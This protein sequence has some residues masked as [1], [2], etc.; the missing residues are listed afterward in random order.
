[1]ATSR[2]SSAGY[3][4][5][6]TPPRTVWTVVRGDTAS[7]KVYVTDDAK[8]PLNIPD[9]TISMEIKRPNSAANAGVITSDATLVL[10]LNPVADPDD[11]PGEF[12]VNLTSTQSALLETGDIFDIQLSYAEN[13]IV[14]TVTQGSMN[15]LE[16]VTG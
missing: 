8:L 12:T 3:N 16:S 9:W 6:N 2:G 4:V 15:V 13:S 11:L 14:W 10:T 7:F 5:G 1:M